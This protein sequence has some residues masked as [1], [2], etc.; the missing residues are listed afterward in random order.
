[1]WTVLFFADLRLMCDKLK[2]LI[3]R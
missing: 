3:A 1:M 2:L